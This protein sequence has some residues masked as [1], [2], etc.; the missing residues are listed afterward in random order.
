M[1]TVLA[2]ANFGES[3]VLEI[4][5]LVLAVLVVVRWVVPPLRR[6]MNAQLETVRDQLAA[7]DEAREATARLVAQRRVDLERSQAEAANLVEQAR[8]SAEQVVADGRRRGEEEHQRLVARAAAEVV[9]A[10]SRAREAV[11]RRVAALVV[12]AAEFV[13]DA[14]LDDTMHHHLIVEAIEAAEAEAV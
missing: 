14:E 7:G 11:T 4:V 1:A 5:G 2:S 13:I 3:Y 10:R 6:A 12:E 9:L 8:L